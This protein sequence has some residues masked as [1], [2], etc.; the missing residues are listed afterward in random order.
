MAND[1]L[2]T[3]LEESFINKA[4]ELMNLYKLIC[5]HSAT[6]QADMA[7]MCGHIHV[8]QQAVMAQAAA[9]AY[10]ELYRLAGETKR[11]APA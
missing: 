1:E 9:R 10:P 3:T 2:L 8:I 5:G 11:H 4:G 7:E 6:R